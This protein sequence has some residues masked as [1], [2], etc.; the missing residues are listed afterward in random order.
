MKG[1]GICKKESHETR[2]NRRLMMAMVKSST[3]TFGDEKLKV[4]R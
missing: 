4:E 1:G 3:M 2:H